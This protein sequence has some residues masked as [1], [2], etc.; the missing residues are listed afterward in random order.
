MNKLWNSIKKGATVVL[1]IC[2]LISVLSAQIDRKLIR[3]YLM[4][5]FVFDKDGVPVSGARVIAVLED[6]NGIKNE[7]RTNEQGKWTLPFLM[8]GKWIVSA[9][10]EGM[11]SEFKDVFLE[12][13]QSGV[14]LAL[15]RTEAEFMAEVKTGIYNEELNQAIQILSWFADNFPQSRELGSALFWISYACERLSRDQKNRGEAVRLNQKALSNLERL[16]TDLPESRWRDAAEMLQITIALRLYQMGG[17]RYAEIIENAL[18]IQDKD[19]FDTKLAAIDALMWIDQPRAFRLLSDIALDDPDPEG[20]KKAVL[21]LGQS[22]TKE[23]LVLLKRIA[24]QDP[25]SSVRKAAV[26]WLERLSK[27]EM[28]PV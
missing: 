19:R 21:I 20:R 24:K 1:V 13:N 5:G 15:T 23:A 11:M 6:W 10:T 2:F 12:S 3:D 4:T 18:L 16:V 28:D 14:V 27:N 22:G 7:A 17:H 25:A 26:I 9:S 8:K